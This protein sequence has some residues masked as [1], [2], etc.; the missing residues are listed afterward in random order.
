[1]DPKIGQE[2]SS[3]LATTD[4]KVWTTAKPSTMVEWGAAT[5][6]GA[7]VLEA[8]INMQIVLQKVSFQFSRFRLTCSPLTLIRWIPIQ[9]AIAR[10]VLC[11]SHC[12]FFLH[13][14]NGVLVDSSNVIPIKVI[15]ET[16]HVKITIKR[17][18]ISLSG[19]NVND[20]IDTLITSDTDHES[21]L[22]NGSISE[23]KKNRETLFTFKI[24][25]CEFYKKEDK[26]G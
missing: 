26:F 20:N 21:L 8:F 6:I 4:E 10:I 13:P 22:V 14:V 12:R 18:Q 9:N 15:L 25:E 19:A 3:C 17:M 7:D 24:L 2:A 23:M 1:M 11:T 5:R 16:I